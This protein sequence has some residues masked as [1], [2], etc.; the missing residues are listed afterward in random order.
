VLVGRDEAKLQQ[1]AQRLGGGTTFQVAESLSAIADLIASQ[2]PTIVLNTIGPFIRTASQIAHACPPGT[3]YID[4]SNELPS[5]QAI[6]A[7]HDHAVA[8]GST[9][10]TGAGFGVLATESVVLK[11][12]E[13]HPPATRVR[14]AA[15]P[16]V[17]VEPGP[18]GEAFAASITEGLAFGGRRYEGGQLVRASALGDFE[19]V[20]LPGGRTVGTTSA[21]S[22][23][24]EAARRASGAAFAV[25]ATSM[26]PSP[27]ILRVIVPPLLTFMKI[28][29]VRRF[30]ARRIAAIEI[31][32]SVAKEPQVSW[33]H[34]RVEWP[35]GE[36]KQGWMRTGDAMDFTADVLA[37]VTIRLA[38]GE[39]VPG[40]Y[41]PGALFGPE[42]ANQCGGEFF[43]DTAEA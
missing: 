16:A 27:S 15:I 8:A 12:C 4:L 35:T 40:A 19:R 39:G 23:E 2:R 24:L 29:P 10:V 43:I 34:A 31:K 28:G 38:K 41:T 30:A 7:L 9:F 32:P 37:R 33:S 11:L 5:V 17:A 3:H 21:S 1:N 14:C 6:L 25:A 13:N 26:V 20:P 36:V 22:G 18:L 42:L